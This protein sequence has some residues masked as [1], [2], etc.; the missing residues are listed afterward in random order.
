MKRRG[1][2][3]RLDSRAH[4]IYAFLYV[5]T[6]RTT[7]TWSTTM[8]VAAVLSNENSTRNARAHAAQRIFQNFRVY[9]LQHYSS[10]FFI[11]IFRGTIKFL[12][13]FTHLSG[14]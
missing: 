13:V 11:L 8:W 14:R 2:E 3:T 1:G 12:T 7:L 4:W 10:R 5:D 9:R 6:D